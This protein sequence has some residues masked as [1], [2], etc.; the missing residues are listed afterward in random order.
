MF[1][2]S[3]IKI[4][5]FL[6]D[7]ITGLKHQRNYLLIVDVVIFTKFQL[8][9][10]GVLAAVSTRLSMNLVILPIT[11]NCIQTLQP[12]KKY[13]ELQCTHI[14][15]SALQYREHNTDQILQPLKK[16]KV[17]RYPNPTANRQ[18]GKDIGIIILQQMNKSG[19]PKAYCQ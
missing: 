9:L 16:G 6:I 17:H 13:E 15:L 11:P 2:W 5:T 7:E 18:V 12:I 4:I 10:M 19:K 14:L 3:T 8:M 1:A